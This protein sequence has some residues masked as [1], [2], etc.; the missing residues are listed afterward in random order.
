MGDLECYFSHCC[1]IN[2]LLA[3]HFQFL[4]VYLLVYLD[5][6]LGV[7]SLIAVLSACYWLLVSSL[8]EFTFF[9]TNEYV[10]HGDYICFIMISSS[11]IFSNFSF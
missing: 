2:L 8:K 4:R 3:S 10:L 6:L 5:D 11:I 1:A 9:S 7:I